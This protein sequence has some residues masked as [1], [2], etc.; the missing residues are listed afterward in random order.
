[1]LISYL[2]PMFRKISNSLAY[3]G[4]K[5]RFSFSESLQMMKNCL[6]RDLYSIELINKNVN[7][8][9]LSMAY[10]PGVGAVCEAIETDPSV[11]DTMTLRPRSVAIVSDG[12]LLDCSEEGIAPTMDWFIAQ[13]KYYSGLDAFPFIV[14]K[15]IDLNEYLKDFATSYGTVLYLDNK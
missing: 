1:M 2:F 6:S 15:D 5:S 3:C 7:R 4:F 13:I 9:I 12:S 8:R 11:A 10:S 14:A